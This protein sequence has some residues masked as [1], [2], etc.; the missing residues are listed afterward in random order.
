MRILLDRLRSRD[1][2]FAAELET[3]LVREPFEVAADA[4]IVRQ[5]EAASVAVLGEAPPH[6][7]ENPW[8]DSALLAGAGIETVVMGP[9]GAGAHAAEEWVDLGSVHRFA[10][11]LVE[12]A[13]RW[14]RSAAD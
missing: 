5:L 12:T 1:S 2:A 11:I 3:L 14:C 4:G 10:E 13:R 7:G 8:M 9:C 6:V